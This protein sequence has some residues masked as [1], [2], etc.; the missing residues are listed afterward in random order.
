MELNL[1]ALANFPADE[2]WV[3]RSQHT[4]GIPL[5]KPLL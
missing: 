3:D 5:I 4:L 1:M 2:N